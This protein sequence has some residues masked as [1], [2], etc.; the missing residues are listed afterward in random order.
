VEFDLDL[1]STWDDEIVPL[2]E[3]QF[4]HHRT[5]LGYPDPLP[6]RRSTPST[7]CGSCPIERLPHRPFLRHGTNAMTTQPAAGV[8]IPVRDAAAS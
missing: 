6:D 4:A 2:D 1:A 7:R 8:L 5:T 3:E